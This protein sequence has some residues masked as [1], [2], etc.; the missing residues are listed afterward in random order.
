MG[1]WRPRWRPP[2][3]NVMCRSRSCVCVWRTAEGYN[4]RWLAQILGTGTRGHAINPGDGLWKGIWPQEPQQRLDELRKGI[5]VLGLANW[6]HRRKGRA[7]QE[8]K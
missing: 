8:V 1:Q 6:K 2:P 4:G 3:P 5:S 7:K